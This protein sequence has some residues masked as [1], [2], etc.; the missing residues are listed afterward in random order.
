MKMSKGYC[1]GLLIDC[2]L[3]PT[4]LSTDS[5]PG[6]GP[7]LSAHRPFPAPAHAQESHVMRARQHPPAF[8][9]T[10]DAFLLPVNGQPIYVLCNDAISQSNGAAAAAA[11]CT[12]STEAFVSLAVD[13]SIRV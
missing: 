11:A 4:T 2:T 8:T 3:V 7:L 9:F 13:T 5:S 1:S 6:Q 10:C 12:C